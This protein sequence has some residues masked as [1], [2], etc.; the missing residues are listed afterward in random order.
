ME[1]MKYMSNLESY[2]NI[3]AD[4][5]QGAYNGRPKGKSFPESVFTNE[6]KKHLKK[7]YET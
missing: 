1:L 7:A 5:A 6:Q 4:L 2:E 3:F